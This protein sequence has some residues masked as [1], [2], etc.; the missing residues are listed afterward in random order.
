MEDE[1]SNYL[2]AIDRDSCYRV[3]ATLKRG[4]LETTERVYFV[5][6]NGAELG[7]FVRKRLDATSGLGG[8]YKT[9]FA[10]QGRGERLSHLPRAALAPAADRR[11]PPPGRPARRG[12]GARGRRDARRGGGALGRPP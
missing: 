7:P 5:G 10:A 4:R 11:V 6:E 12:H 1:L 8:A 2:A 9:V 3:D